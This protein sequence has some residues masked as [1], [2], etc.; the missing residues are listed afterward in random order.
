MELLLII[1]GFILIVGIINCVYDYKM[2]YGPK[3]KEK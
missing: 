3:N 2:K 1:M